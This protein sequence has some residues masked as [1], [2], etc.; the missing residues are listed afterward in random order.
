[1]VLHQ[2]KV[3]V[4]IKEADMETILRWCDKDSMIVDFSDCKYLKVEYIPKH[5]HKHDHETNE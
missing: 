3:F 1:M 4:F 2:K 5:K